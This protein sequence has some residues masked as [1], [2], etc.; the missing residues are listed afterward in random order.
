MARRRLDDWITRYLEYTASSESPVSFHLWAGVSCIAAALQRKVYIRW[1]H[2]TIYPNNYIVLVGP[3][4]R[5]RKGEAIGIARGLVESLKLPLIGEDNSME[6]IILE[7]KN[8]VT[9]FKDKG[10]GNLTLQ[11]AVSSFVEELSVFTGEQNKVFLSYLTNWYDSRDRW[12][13]STKHMGIDEI[14]G[15]CFNLLAAT[16]PDWVPYILPREAIGGGF[17]SRCVFIVEASKSKIVADPNSIKQPDQLR[18]DLAFDLEVIHTL[19]GEMKFE[20]KAKK[21]YIEWYEDQEKKIEEGNPPIPDPLF[22]GYLARRPMHLF[23]TMMAMSASRGG[24]MLL[25]FKD[26]K[27][28]LSMLEIA[29]KK[30]PRVFSGIGSARYAAETEMIL[31]YIAAKRSVTKAELLTTFY[32]Q[33]DDYSLDIVMKVLNGMKIVQTVIQPGKDIRYIYT[34]KETDPDIGSAIH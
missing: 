6:S 31:Q 32:K 22:Q 23:K 11:C 10:N 12:K 14:M 33:V 7:M 18:K 5:S 20:D 28:A 26:F 16:A 8:S 24:D 27:R 9:T 1:G 4:G 19:S 13:R 15:M 2:S 17:T 29:E 3:S 30:M 34:R 25:T 21:A